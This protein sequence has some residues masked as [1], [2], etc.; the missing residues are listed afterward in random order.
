MRQI[1]ECLIDL[2]CHHEEAVSWALNVYNVWFLSSFV[3]KGFPHILLILPFFLNIHGHQI[4]HLIDLVQDF[5]TSLVQ[6][7]PIMTPIDLLKCA[8]NVLVRDLCGHLLALMEVD[9][10]ATQGA[11]RSLRMV[12]L[13]AQV[14]Q[15]S[16]LGG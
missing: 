7:L 12:L 6:C 10:Q 16:H 3:S 8:V 5:S 14:D 9:A 2:L 1:L 15:L 4:K 11:E 13:L